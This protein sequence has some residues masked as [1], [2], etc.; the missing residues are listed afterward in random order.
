VGR[1]SGCRGLG[2]YRIYHVGSGDRLRLGETFHATSDDEAVKSAR[3]LLSRGQPA[4]LWEGGRIVG[5]FS[6]IHDFLPG[7]G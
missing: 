7:G 4:E 5:R 1:R 3:P 6:K 2:T